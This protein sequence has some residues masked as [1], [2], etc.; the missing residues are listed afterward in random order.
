[1][2]NNK[3]LLTKEKL[4]DLQKELDD[5]VNVKRPEIIK[6][7][8]EARAQGDLR[9]NA[10]Y[11]AAK[12]QQGDIESRINE[13]QSILNNYEIIDTKKNQKQIVAIGKT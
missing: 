11:D 2:S 7:I 12:D 1:M 8:Q 3:V 9:E 13:I 6:I 5:L 10:D 4:D